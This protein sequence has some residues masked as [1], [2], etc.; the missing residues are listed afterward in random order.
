MVKSTT[1]RLAVIETKLETIQS[2]VSEI[3]ASI[4]EHIIWEDTK[5]EEMKKQFAAKWSERAVTG[6][7]ATIVTAVIYAILK[8]V[9]L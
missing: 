8:N 3:K 2:D 1:E 4:K 9:G 6:L 7:I 5:Y